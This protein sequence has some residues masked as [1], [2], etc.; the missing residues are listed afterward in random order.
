MFQAFIFCPRYK[1]SW[2][3]ST[4]WW[5]FIALWCDHDFSSLWRLWNLSV[6]RNGKMRLFNF[7]RDL[8]IPKTYSS[9]Y[10]YSKVPFSY[11]SL[12]IKNVSLILL[13]WCILGGS[14]RKILCT[15]VHF[16][17]M[18]LLLHHFS[19][20]VFDFDVEIIEVQQICF[21][22]WFLKWLAL[23]CLLKG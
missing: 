4:W 10:S 21:I 2:R 16:C 18:F 1:V 5:S 8:P 17:Y 15:S 6:W 19:W 22:I 20:G 9:M 3:W 7:S 12:L 11:S 14:G 23:S 13:I